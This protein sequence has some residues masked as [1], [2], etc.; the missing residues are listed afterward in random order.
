MDDAGSA[1]G[2]VILVLVSVLAI[3]FGIVFIVYHVRFLIDSVRNK[4]LG[5]GRLLWILFLFFC[6]P[7]AD[8]LYYGAVWSK[9]PRPKPKDAEGRAASRSV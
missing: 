8:L 6:P 7:F 5:P 3:T 4:S 2:I 9:R 1:K